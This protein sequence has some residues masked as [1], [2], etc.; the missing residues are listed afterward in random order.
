MMREIIKINLRTYRQSKKQNRIGNSLKR[1]E[2]IKVLT[3][4]EVN[5]YMSG[6]AEGIY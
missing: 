3:G 6:I 1:D 5:I 4:K 2:L